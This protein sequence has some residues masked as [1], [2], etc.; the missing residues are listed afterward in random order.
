MEA[1]NYFLDLRNK[2]VAHAVNDYE[3]T[4]V[5]AYLTDSSFAQRAVTRTGQVHAEILSCDEGDPETLAQLAEHFTKI[6]N[7][8]LWVLHE[9]IG[10]EL[11]ELGEAAVYA[12][13]DLVV[14]SP[15]RAK[16]GKR[17]R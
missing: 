10:R 6:I 9:A 8:R 3:H 16:V 13:E 17:R 4:I 1:H 15:Q 7:R 12:L 11:H 14:P 5:V 2:H